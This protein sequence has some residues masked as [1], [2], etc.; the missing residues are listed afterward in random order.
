[1][2][3]FTNCIQLQT[4]SKYLYTMKSG[5]N[6]GNKCNKTHGDYC[7]KH[8]KQITA[9]VEDKQHVLKHLLKMI[10]QNKHVVQY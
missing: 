8:L 5:K 6:K 4:K 2:G 1:M 10:R 9:N 3:K 7:S